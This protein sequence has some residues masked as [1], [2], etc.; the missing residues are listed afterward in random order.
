MK[1]IRSTAILL[2]KTRILFI[3]PVLACLLGIF[4]SEAKKTLTICPGKEKSFPI[5]TYSDASE[6]GKT[7]ISEPL[8][9]SN[10]VTFEYTLQKFA[11][12]SYA[13]L[14]ITLMTDSGF[15]DISKYN[16]L[17]LDLEAGK[18]KSLAV[19][20]KAFMDG[21]TKINEFLTHEFLMREI[22][23]DSVRS[24][25]TISLEE[26]THPTWWLEDNNFAEASIGKPHFSKMTS[27]ELQNGIST[28]YDTPVRV[29]VHKI[30]FVK[31][32]S[33]AIIVIVG[34]TLLYF[35]LYMLA[36]MIVQ[37]KIKAKQTVISYKELAVENDAD[38][39]MQRVT[40]A[41]AKHFADP[42]F[43]VEKL[44]REAGVS[45]SRIPGMLKERFS[46]N[47]K[48]YLNIIR[49][50]EA[51]RLLRETDNQI[52]TCA[53][54]VGYNNIPHFNRTFKQLEGISPK[55][56]RKGLHDSGKTGSG[57]EKQ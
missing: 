39:D 32:N 19:Y 37:K 36:F 55:E 56:Y 18:S 6:K 31:D 49:I 12:Y 15:L 42:E 38:K 3:V 29:I 24:Q 1:K 22:R 17:V 44:A 40:N 8:L 14:M 34:C 33:F 54:N 2:H 35:F 50:T 53:Y 25:Y 21:I 23:V 11:E 5:Q 28:P 16:Y 52:T 7:T 48:Q 47:F 4:W 57:Q 13:G 41:V 46:M 9:G 27:I 20:L 10:Q 26:F 45:A 43:T 51:K 30:A